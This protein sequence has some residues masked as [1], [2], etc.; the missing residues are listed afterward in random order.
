MNSS[1]SD[2]VKVYRVTFRGSN[3]ACFIFASLLNGSQFVEERI[4]FHRE[5]ILLP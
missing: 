3:S 2:H 4:C 1:D 5:K